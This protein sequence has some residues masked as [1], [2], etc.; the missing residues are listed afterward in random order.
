M[1]LIATSATRGQ[2]DYL[3]RVG[4]PSFTTAMPVEHGFINLA[5]GNLHLEIPL[6]SFPQR[7]GQSYEAKIVYDSSIWTPSSGAWSTNNVGIGYGGRG[8]WRSISSGSPGYVAYDDKPAGTCSRDGKTTDNS[9]KN[10]S[11]TAPDGTVHNFRTGTPWTVPVRYTTACLAGSWGGVPHDAV[12]D[13]GLGYH[14]FVTAGCLQ[15]YCKPIATVYA[16]DG[17]RVNGGTVQDSNGNFYNDQGAQG[18]DTLARTLINT[19]GS[20]SL[21]YHD[22]L[23]SQGGTSRYT[24]Q[25]EQVNVNTAFGTTNLEYSGTLSVIQS[26]TLPDG[27]S[28]SFTYDAGTTSGHYGLLTSMT[29][30]TGAVINYGY[31]NFTDANSRVARWVTSRSTSDGN[32]SYI[33]QVIP[34]CN[35]FNCQQVTVTK[36][37]GDSAVY[38]FLPFLN[39][40]GTWPITVQHYNGSPSP[41][42]LLATLNQCWSFSTFTNG[43]CSSPAIPPLLYVHKIASTTTVPLPDGTNLNETTQFAWDS[44]NYGNLVQRSEWN[45]Y[46]GSLPAV[47]DRTVSYAYLNTAP[48]L[49]ANIVN[50]PTA[51]TTTDKNGNIVSQTLYTYDGSTLTTVSG[52]TNHDDTNYGSSNTVRGNLTQVQQLVSGT[53]NFITTSK[54]YDT[55]GQATTSTDGNGNVT[56]YSYADNFFNDS[57]DTSNPVPYTPPTPTN[58]YLKSITRGPLT[59]SFGYYWGTGQK[60]LSTD[61]N[62][63]TTYFHYFD[64]L[65]RPTSSKMPDSGWIFTQYNSTETQI[66]T[67]IGITS[68][69]P[70]TN[71]PAPSNA[72]RH[73]QTL[74]DSLGRVTSSVL[75]SDPDGAT[76]TATAYDSNGRVLKTSNPYRSTSDLTYGWTSNTYDGLNRVTQVQRQDSSLA[77]TFYGAQVTTPG[78]IASQLC[79]S[80][81]YGLGYPVLAVDEAGKKRQTWTDGFG[82]TIEADEPDS[83][84][85]LTVATC[86]S[87]DLNNN[88]VGA[89]QNGSRQRTFAYDSLSRLTSATNP[90]SGTIQYAYDANGNLIGKLD[91]R[92]IATYY[93]YDALNRLVQKTFSDSTPGSFYAYDQ[94]TYPGY[95]T[96]P[97]GR[98][99]SEGTF[100]G[101]CWPTYSIFGYDTMGRVS[102]Q[103]DYLNTAE[104]SGCPGAWSTISASYDLAGN[105]TSLTY[106]SGRVVKSQFNGANR[107]T[108]TY[109]DDFNGYNYLSSASYAPFGS[110]TTFALG[111]GATET[112]TYNKRLQPL[113]Q[114]LRNTT[115]TLLNRSYS[116]NDGSGHNNGNVISIAD[117]LNSSLTQNFSYDSLNRLYTAQTAG[118]SG[119]DCW[120][121]QFGYDAWGNLLTETPNVPGCPTNMLNLGVNANN[122][123]TNTGFAYD[124]AGNMTNDGTNTYAFDAE[125]HLTSLNSGTAT[126]IY[127]AQGRRMVKKI[128]SSTTEYIYFNGDVLAEYN[129]GSQ[130]WSDYIFAGGR[131]L[132]AAGTDDIFNPGFEQGLEGWSTGA[133][134]SSGSTQLITDP[135]RAHSGNKYL[136]LSTTT[137]QV[138]AGNQV[139]AVNPGDQ[140]TF[141]GWAYLESGSASGVYVGWNLIVRDANGNVLAYPV[142][143]NATSATWTYQSYTYTV[144]SGGASVSLYAQ[145]YLPTGSTTARFD[146]G[147]LTGASGLGV[148]YYHADHL[149]SA[150]LMTDASGNQTWSATYLPFGQEWNPQATTNHYKFTGYERDSESSLDYATARHYS[151]NFARFMSPDPLSGSPG[152]PQS[153]N[154][155]SYVNNNPLNATDPSGMCSEEDGYSDCDWNWDASAYLWYWGPGLGPDTAGYEG[156]LNYSYGDP[157]ASG[158]YLQTGG[159]F[160]FNST[161]QAYPDDGSIMSQI[162]NNPTLASNWTSTFNNA[163]GLVTD[164]TAFVAQNAL[165]AS[166]VGAG[167]IGVR[168]LSILQILSTASMAGSGGPGPI[169]DSLAYEKYWQRYAPDQVTP[170]TGRLDFTRQSGR[171]GRFENS[172]VIYDD[173]GRQ[174]YRIDFTDHMRPEV[175]SDP[176]LHV[177]EYGPGYRPYRE[178]IFDFLFDIE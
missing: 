165:I 172:R 140:L 26:I 76:T 16:P 120:G 125:N 66:D 129:L 173:F 55:T 178:S 121:Q 50:R 115:S 150:R 152:N 148:H 29:L 94:I 118:T 12:S 4:V 81:T 116:F 71:C 44:T 86:Y 157:L 130:V 58:A 74:L 144:T 49:T 87:Y 143:G 1:A 89:V 153:W 9:F 155:Y 97:I 107:L 20:P 56:T 67:G 82:R 31:A 90:E 132:A 64:P 154:R 80:A 98:L 10:F 124:A 88:L 27:A 109:V 36:P 112:S 25:T 169:D 162:M 24:V 113:N 77:K 85:S 104:T 92:G 176:H 127:D 147:F 174:R 61:P 166:G 93:G 161:T 37:S 5:T 63:Q 126:Y 177:Y 133:S 23:N 30:P 156:W 123:I 128:G 2:D 78:G 142:A 32:W 42:N 68:T 83:T 135:A 137:A 6:G 15:P 163:N 13:D 95:Q 84:G 122:Q 33:P 39:G 72:C 100:D 167:I 99:T 54:T 14:I 105:Q 70:T 141:G 138:I 170:G 79:S 110:P 40:H 57:G 117:N 28:Y 53:S 171:T 21:L 3:T 146:D 91:A 102:F 17:T 45:F 139:V 119:P 168:G 73:D 69:A 62:N 145:I 43:V 160:Y 18:T 65:S 7:G 8:G 131:R 164:A 136:Q 75:V 101:T 19:T 46:S 59:N 159:P 108:K 106:P 51:V 111:N 47:A 158:P 11:W 48:Y 175:H 34:P 41:S 149:G 52:V 151:S 35:S 60:A 38:T 22:V 114:Q 96:N 134:D 103:E